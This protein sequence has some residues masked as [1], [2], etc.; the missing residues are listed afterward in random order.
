MKAHRGWLRVAGFCL[1][2]VPAASAAHAQTGD[3]P[4]KVV[5]VISDAGAGAAPDV[6]TRF[7]A[8][9]LGR[10]WGQQVVVI[11]RPGGNGS[12]AAHAAAEAVGDGYTLYAPCSRPS[13]RLRAWRR[14]FR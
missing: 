11:N 5:T 1:L 4:S 3:Y 14:T 13:W 10:L 2:L 7:V 6:V 9:G 8:E 12:I